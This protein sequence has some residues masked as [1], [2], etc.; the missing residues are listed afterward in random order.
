MRTDS[1]SENLQTALAWENAGGKTTFCFG[2]IYF[3]GWDG[4]ASFLNHFWQKFNFS[5]KHI[6]VL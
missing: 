3:I 5:L 4:A 6:N 1:E 2:L